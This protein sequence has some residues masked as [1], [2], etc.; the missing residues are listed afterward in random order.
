[1]WINLFKT[2]KILE[3]CNNNKQNL[4]CPQILCHSF[5]YIALSSDHSLVTLTLPFKVILR[6]FLRLFSD[7]WIENA[8][9]FKRLMKIHSNPPMYTMDFTC[10]YNFI[11]AFLSLS[12]WCHSGKYPFVCTWIFTHFHIVTWEP[13]GHYVAVQSLEALSAFLVLMEYGV[14]PFWFSWSMELHPSGSQPIFLLF[15]EP[16]S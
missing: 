4:G 3:I 15:I 2:I 10:S 16:S 14:T 12:L 9:L 5:M 8:A 7:V 1:M 6:K 11:F 13:E